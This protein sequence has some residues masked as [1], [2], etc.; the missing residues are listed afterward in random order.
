MASKVCVGVPEHRRPPDHRANMMF[1]LRSGNLRRGVG[2][3][4]LAGIDTV[5]P[6]RKVQH[7]KKGR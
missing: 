7:E 6:G 4:D 3:L 2:R 1:L 5:L